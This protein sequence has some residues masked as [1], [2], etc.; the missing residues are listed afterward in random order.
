MKPYPMMMRAYCLI[1]LCTAEIGYILTITPT[2][3]IYIV[4]Y[5]NGFRLK[6]GIIHL[7]CMNRESDHIPHAHTFVETK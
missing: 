1:F 6:S 7:F 4:V 5:M 2:Y 3:R